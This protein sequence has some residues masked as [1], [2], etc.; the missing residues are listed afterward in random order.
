LEV[1]GWAAGLDVDREGESR[2]DCLDRCVH[3]DRGRLGVP[4]RGDVD[5]VEQGW[6]CA[7]DEGSR[8]LATGLRGAVGHPRR[9]DTFL[10]RG[11]SDVVGVPVETEL[12]DEHDEQQENWDREDELDG[13]APRSR[14]RAITVVSRW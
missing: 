4:A 8:S 6:G 13:G 5:V 9:A 3:V 1:F 14:R 2:H 12:H 7:R 10:G 11:L